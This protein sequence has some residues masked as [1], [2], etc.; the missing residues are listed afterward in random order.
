MEEYYKNIAIVLKCLNVKNEADL[1]H[2]WEDLAKMFQE[3]K[4]NSKAFQDLT[5]VAI[6]FQKELKAKHIIIAQEKNYEKFSPALIDILN[7]FDIKPQNPAKLFQC[8]KKYAD[9]HSLTELSEYLN[10][11]EVKVD[12]EEKNQLPKEP[13]IIKNEQHDT[14]LIAYRQKVIKFLSYFYDF[15]I[16]TIQ[17]Q[18]NNQYIIDII[19]NCNHDINKLITKT[20]KDLSTFNNVD[21]IN[22]YMRDNFIKEYHE[23]IKNF[24][25]LYLNEYNTSD[26]DIEK[27]LEV[28]NIEYKLNN[29]IR[30]MRLRDICLNL[31]SDLT[32]SSLKESIL[33]IID[34]L[35]EKRII[36]LGTKTVNTLLTNILENQAS[37]IELYNE[38][39]AKVNDQNIEKGRV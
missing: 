18:F 34:Y 24:I 27:Y 39:K 12:V 3:E 29:N 6:D 36:D 4:Y 32:I 38:L 5:K 11:P 23:I 26:E 28:E 7:H 30:E 2:I 33:K 8:L 20:L 31:K 22:S 10:K 37:L 21:E 13:S 15:D 16:S 19:S 25:R 17:N 35:Y 1:N 14:N 9:N